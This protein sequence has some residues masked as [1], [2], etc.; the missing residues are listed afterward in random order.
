MD[1]EDDQPLDIWR[2]G[3]WANGEWWSEVALDFKP[4]ALTPFGDQ[5]NSWMI[6][7]ARGEVLWI[8]DTALPET[9][10]KD[11]VAVG[12]QPSFTAVHRFAAGLAVAQMARRIY[13]S[14]G[15]EWQPL[16][17]NLTLEKPG[18]LVGFESLA[19]TDDELYACGWG[20][21]IWFLKDGVWQEV[22]SPTNIILTSA[23]SQQSELIMCGRLGTI[24][25]GRRDRWAIVEHHQTDEDFWSVATFQGRVYL[26]SMQ[27]I[28]E[29]VDD[30]LVPVDDGSTTG[31][32]YH[33]SANDQI[34]VSTGAR[35]VLVTDGTEWH[36]II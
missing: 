26:S 25:R 19:A 6:L 34:M 15:H 1:G 22:H 16:G 3:F 33:L 2:V 36:E 27:A 31:S 29:L 32:Y 10:R 7:G 12:P 20:G 11:R 9:F 5:Q 23:A 21:E 13:W 17:T 8:A 24:L 18:E 35:S 14:D 4:V 28:Y 30:R